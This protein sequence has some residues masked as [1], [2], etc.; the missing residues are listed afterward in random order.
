M[1]FTGAQLQYLDHLGID[2][3]VS[4]DQ[5][6]S[7]PVPSELIPETAEAVND[8][9]YVQASVDASKSVEIAASQVSTPVQ[10][11]QP[12]VSQEVHA[13]STVSTQPVKTKAETIISS[14]PSSAPAFP[15]ID[16]GLAVTDTE[17]KP[18]AEMAQSAPKFNI[19]FWCYSSGLWIVSGNVDLLPEHHKLAH[20]I[21]QYVQ[22]KKREPSH[23]GIF[24][25]PMLDSPNV[26]QGPEVASKHLKDYIQRLQQSH[27]VKHVI[28]FSDCS[29]WFTH[30]NSINVDFTLNDTLQSVEHKQALWKTILPYVISE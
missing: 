10:N 22:G 2:V 4:R 15:K 23:L 20:N 19:Q 29:E 25:W 16:P 24:S 13:G 27:T 12:V 7:Q 17:A 5:L 8:T 3:W 28:A 11:N 18:A 14:T 30:L 26:D 9:P 1:E 21:A 6:D